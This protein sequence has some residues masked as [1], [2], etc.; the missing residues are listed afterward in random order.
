M[1]PQVLARRRLK[2]C[3]FILEICVPIY[4]RAIEAEEIDTLHRWVDATDGALSVV[5][6]FRR[7]GDD[8][9]LDIGLA[10][11]TPLR[12]RQ[13]GVD[14]VLVDTVLAFALDRGQAPI[15]TLG[16]DVYA[17]VTAITSRPLAPTPDFGEACFVQGIGAQHLCHKRFEGSP[18]FPLIRVSLAQTLVH[19][20][21]A[22]HALS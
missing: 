7:S 1:R 5:A 3:R 18:S 11:E 20:G 6:P 13:E 14:V 15:V 4:G 10:H 2:R 19:I 8:V 17:N 16:Y 22:A 12:F 9:P 21:E